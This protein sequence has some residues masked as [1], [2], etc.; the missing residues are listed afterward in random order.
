MIDSFC[1]T[2]HYLMENKTK[3]YTNRID[4]KVI[5]PIE[6]FS[7]I[8]IEPKRNIRANANFLGLIQEFQFTQS[9]FKTII[10]I[11]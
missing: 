5:N 1:T 8:Y 3:K 6:N 4:S 9:Q 2:A 10:S 11:S 7:L